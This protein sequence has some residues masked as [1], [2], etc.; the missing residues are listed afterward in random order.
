MMVGSEV[1]GKA[2]A[3]LTRL[4]LTA[5]PCTEYTRVSLRCGLDTIVYKLYRTRRKVPGLD[6]Q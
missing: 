6:S 4:G 1:K 5:L 2:A 3:S